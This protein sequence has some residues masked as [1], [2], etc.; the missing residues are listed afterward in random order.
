[1]NDAALSSQQQRGAQ[2][3]EAETALKLLALISSQVQSRGAKEE[4][5]SW[6]Y[7]RVEKIELLDAYTI[8]RRISIDFVL[9]VVS[10]GEV[11]SNIPYLPIAWMRRGNK[12]R[13]FDLRDEQGCSIPVATRD[14]SDRLARIGLESYALAIV[15]AAAADKPGRPSQEALVDAVKEDLASIAV[16]P[17]ME[18][19][20]TAL[21]R[22]EQSS[23]ADLGDDSDDERFQRAVIWRY[24][25]RGQDRSL[26]FVLSELLERFP[27]LAVIPESTTSA[28]ADD[29]EQT[30]ARRVL[31]ISW[32][33][34]DPGRGRQG[35]RRWFQTRMGWAPVNVRLATSQLVSTRSY[36]IEM[37][38]PSDDIEIEWAAL[39]VAERWEET[40]AGDRSHLR[41]ALGDLDKNAGDA[42]PLGGDT[43]LDPFAIFALRPARQGFLRLAFFSCLLSTALLAAGLWRLDDL[44]REVEGTVT[45][46]IFV[47]GL[48]SLYAVRT[49]E[50]ALA[51]Q[52]FSGVRSMVITAALCV[53]V[54]GLLLIL[55]IDP[56]LRE[57]LW[58]GLVTIAGLAT[59]LVAWSNFGPQSFNTPA[60]GEP[61]VRP[62]ESPKPY[63]ESDP[64]RFDERPVIAF[65]VFT[66]VLA[67]CMLAFPLAGGRELRVQSR[68]EAAI[69]E[70]GAQSSA[71]DRRLP[72]GSFAE[73][74]WTRLYVF[75][76]DADDTL[77]TQALS[78]DRV[79]SGLA[80]GREVLGRSRANETMLVLV[81][82]DDIA[83]VM[84][85]D[86]REVDFAALAHPRQCY[87]TPTNELM[88]EHSETRTVAHAAHQLSVPSPAPC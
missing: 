40:D 18:V 17:E 32:T 37:V 53:L 57:A 36:H 65:A 25:Y 84:M 66:V 14:E 79:E 8:R 6:V 33:D 55:D 75:G 88:V 76:P 24:S 1:M 51:T 64:E 9:P 63:S 20:G 27:L 82:R 21:R 26:R 67:I 78:E 45:L 2:Q 16:D 71:A 10:E 47:P 29:V 15:L 83:E 3:P 44:L 72:L 41:F 11:L 60:K 52:L 80:H 35:L 4:R 22:F 12:L 42:A 46:L 38:S 73:V 87:L 50:H 86:R 39:S 28:T 74:P 81:D 49:G 54:A 48:L 56:V 30:W 43:V 77:V 7:R 85:L 5:D 61:S 62:Q 58:S 70:A 23:E 34:R 19:R 59:L 13:E 68:L 69:A 31:K